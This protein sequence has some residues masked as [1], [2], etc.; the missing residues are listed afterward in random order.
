MYT[1]HM[2][3]FCQFEIKPLSMNYMTTNISVEFKTSYLLDS[4]IIFRLKKVFV[5]EFHRQADT[6]Q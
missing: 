1:A 6:Y 5:D 4:F 2:T 3:L